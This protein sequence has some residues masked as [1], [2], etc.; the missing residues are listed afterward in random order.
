MTNSLTRAIRAEKFSLS[1]HLETIQHSIVRSYDGVQS[2][3]D[4]WL[5]FPQLKRRES[6]AGTGSRARLCTSS[7]APSDLLPPARFYIL[8]K[9]CHPL[10]T[11]CSNTS[12]WRM[13][14]IQ[15][16]TVMRTL[17]SSGGHMS[18]VTGT[19]VEGLFICVSVKD[20]TLPES[21]CIAGLWRMRDGEKIA[22]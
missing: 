16:V 17:R 12:L 20:V 10:V 8:P 18:L 9:Q 19:D 13:I 22:A 15:T 14:Y 2:S 4:M 3:W 5:D 6:R 1:S 11:K 21:F 7:P